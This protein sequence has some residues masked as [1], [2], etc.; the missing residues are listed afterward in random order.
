MSSIKITDSYLSYTIKHYTSCSSAS[1]LILKNTRGVIYHNDDI[2]CK[3]FNFT[4]E[5]IGD[6]EGFLAHMD[7][8]DVQF[9]MALDKKTGKTVWRT[10]RSTD[11]G[12]RDGDFRKAYEAQA[13]LGRIGQPQD[14]APAA[15]FLASSDSA[16]ITGETFYIAGGVR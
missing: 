7:G 13:P 1:D 8:I 11:F 16:W 10:N 14:I 3:T 4:P 12:A 2:V 5:F 15:V 6:K 9:V